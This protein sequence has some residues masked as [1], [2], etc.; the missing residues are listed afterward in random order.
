MD[1]NL[2]DGAIEEIDWQITEIVSGGAKGV[3]KL[4]EDWAEANYMSLKIFPAN[5][6]KYGKS[7]GYKRNEE[8]A[9][10]ADALIAIWDGKS[11]GTKHM[12]DIAKKQGLIVAIF[13]PNQM[14]IN[15][16]N[17]NSL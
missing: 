1:P 5:W 10:Y 9:E 2:I 17:L 14:V 16:T 12:I 7:A 6:Y 13:K 4:G 11:K 15:N 8:M 3:D